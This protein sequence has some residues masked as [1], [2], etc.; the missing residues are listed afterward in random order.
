MKVCTRE[1]KIVN[2]ILEYFFHYLIQ[3]KLYSEMVLSGAG[4]VWARVTE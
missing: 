2:I 4:L 1:Q 3:G